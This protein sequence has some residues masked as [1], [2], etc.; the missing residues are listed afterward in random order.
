[1]E[2]YISITTSSRIMA[3]KWEQRSGSER[4]GEARIII[5]NDLLM[6]KTLRI[7]KG[8]IS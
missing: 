4:D 2:G 7:K 8:D 5:C 6:Y 3:S 1:M